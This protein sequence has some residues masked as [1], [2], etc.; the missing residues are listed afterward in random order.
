M[1]YNEEEVEVGC[2]FGQGYPCFRLWL[3]LGIMHFV[4]FVVVMRSGGIWVEEEA[5]LV[6]NGGEGGVC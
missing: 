5:Y 2:K 6:S 1:V 3:P 4:G